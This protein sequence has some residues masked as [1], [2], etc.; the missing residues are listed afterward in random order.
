MSIDR[1]AVILLLVG[2]G[3]SEVAAG[4]QGQQPPPTAPPRRIVTAI[5]PK[6]IYAPE[7]R[8]PR[9][10][11]LVRIQGPVQ[12]VAEIDE[13][14]AVASLVVQRGHPFLI[15]AAIEVAQQYRYKPGT[16]NGVPVRFIIT[17]TIEFKSEIPPLELV[18]IN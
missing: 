2:V 10:A 15:A 11:N 12:M 3:V 14:G 18:P 7:P 8:T 13:E 1:S 4:L 17:V 5:P 16:G 6:L 9:L